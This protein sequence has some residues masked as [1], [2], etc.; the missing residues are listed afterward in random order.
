MGAYS[1]LVVYDELTKKSQCIKY[2]YV[3]NVKDAKDFGIISL[4]FVLDA[5]GDG[6]DEIIIQETKEFEV[7]YSV[8]ENIKGKYYLVLSSEISI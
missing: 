3:R 6:T 8:F 5:N 2:N 4:K 7:I 1:A